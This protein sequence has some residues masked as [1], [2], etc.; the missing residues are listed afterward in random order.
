M[1]VIL[2]LFYGPSVDFF[3]RCDWLLEKNIIIESLWQWVRNVG[4]HDHWNSEAMIV[5]I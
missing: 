4:S 2:F 5:T 3:W 1:N